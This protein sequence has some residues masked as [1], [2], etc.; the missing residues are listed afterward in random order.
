MSKQLS[1]DLQACLHRLEQWFRPLKGSLTAFSGGI[2][3]SLVLFLSR[4][5]LSRDTA[6][7]CISASESLKQDDL[8]LAR[9]FCR[10]YDIRLE[11]IQ[12]HELEDEQYA[13][14]PANRCFFCKNHLYLDMGAVLAQF[15]GFVVLNGTNTDDLGDYRPGLQAARRHQVKSPLAECGLNKAAVRA[16]ARYFE[17]PNW[18]KPASPCLSSRVPYGSRITAAKLRQIEAAENL[19]NTYG[20]A[21]VRVR[22]Y[23]EEARIEVPASQIVRLK[24]H[25]PAIVPAMQEL[26][27]ESCTIDEEGFISGKL[28]RAL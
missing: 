27:F 18:A 3:S 4:R 21:N 2:D 26:G 14:N 22:H 12:T 11:E 20:F 6:I 25:F 15:P 28:N 17:L 16:L 7:G 24:H 1:P 8:L 19:L 23:G 5:F 10:L 13:S 9:E